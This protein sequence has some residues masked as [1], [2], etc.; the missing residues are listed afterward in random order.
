MSRLYA[1]KEVEVIVLPQRADTSQWVGKWGEVNLLPYENRGWVR[2]PRS[3]L[4]L[5]PPTSRVS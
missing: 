1:Y 2:L 4:S 5:A 3:G